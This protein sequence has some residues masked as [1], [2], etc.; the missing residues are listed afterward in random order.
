MLATMPG[1][2]GCEWEPEVARGP[3]W[4]L[5][6]PRKARV[7]GEPKALEPLSSGE[8][9]VLEA[10]PRSRVKPC[11]LDPT[12]FWDPKDAAAL[13]PITA[14]RSP[15]NVKRKNSLQRRRITQEPRR[16]RQVIRARSRPPAA[17]GRSSV[18]RSCGIISENF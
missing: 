11:C 6:V 8:L 5:E 3:R 16:G 14:A 13:N 4:A 12:I 1:L 18:R 9:E 15:L 10:E 7:T 2:S 17:P